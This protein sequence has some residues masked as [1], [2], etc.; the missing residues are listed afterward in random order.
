[1]NATLTLTPYGG[2]P[3]VTKTFADWGITDDFDGA[4]RSLTPDELNLSLPG[5]ALTAAQFPYRSRT[6]IKIDGMVFFSGYVSDDVSNGSESSNAAALHLAGPWWFLDSLPFEQARQVLVSVDPDGTPT[7]RTDFYTHFTLN[8]PIQC[9]YV[10]GPPSELFYTP[11]LLSSRAQI[12]EIL[13]YAIA[14]GAWL[15]YDPA[16]ILDVPVLP[17]D[18][19]NITC[20]ECIRKQLDDVDAVA[21][22]DHTQSPPKFHCQ[23]RKDLPSLARGLG[24]AQ[25][26]K[27]FSLK[28]RYDLAVPYVLIYFETPTSVGSLNFTSQFADYYPNPLPADKFKALITTVPLRAISGTVHTKFIKTEQIAAD[29]LDWWKRRK[30]ELDSALFAQ[31]AIDYSDLALVPGSDK[32]Q[33]L[34]P[35]HIVDGGYASWMRGNVEHDD[36]MVQAKYHRKFTAHLP[37]TKIS[38]HTLRAGLKATDLN[39]P[40]GINFTYTEYTSLG[41]AV[42]QFVGLAQIIYTDLNMPQW[43]GSIPIFEAAYSG[44]MTLGKNLNLTGGRAEWQTMNALIQEIGFKVRGSGI[45]YTTRVG[46]NKKLSAQ[47]LVDRFRAARQRYLGTVG[48][49]ISA[50]TAVEHTRHHPSRDTSTAEPGVSEH[51]AVDY[52]ADNPPRGGIST[53]SGNGG[54]PMWAKKIVDAVGVQVPNTPSVQFKLS[55]I[56]VADVTAGTGEMQYR[57]VAGVADTNGK[58]LYIPSTGPIGSLGGQAIKTTIDSIVSAN[59]LK[60]KKASDNS[61]IYVAVPTRLRANPWGDPAVLLPDYNVGD[62]IFAIGADNIGFADPDGK[63]VV[64]IDLNVDARQWAIYIQTCEIVNN[65]TSSYKRKFVCSDREAI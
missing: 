37:G 23:R 59:L 50:K 29:D 41:E 25:Q 39:F 53:M 13:D 65:V 52:T 46:A 56:S 64:Y 32:R 1:M 8:L 44:S 21:W 30:P 19:L 42:Q 14:H 18:V 5:A 3:D 12:V 47:Q 2:G 48:G 6:V 28:R 9:N 17:S 36:V 60:C 22:F 38:S 40:A 35:N 33:S 57:K 54:D 63:D 49:S 20:A 31:A 24:N 10:P 16:D 34:L 11:N 61:F 62:V 55:Q 7:Y 27:G 45:N 26:A 51:N 58:P 15:Q 43:D 4:F